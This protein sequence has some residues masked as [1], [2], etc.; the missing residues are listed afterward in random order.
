MLRELGVLGF[1][2]VILG[3]EL[4]DEKCEYIVR[5]VKVINKEELGLYLIVCCGCVDLE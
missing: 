4:D 5:L 3:R 2:L 1:C